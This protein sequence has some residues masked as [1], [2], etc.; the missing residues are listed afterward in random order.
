M[1]LNRANHVLRQR[2]TS[3][4]TLIEMI[5]SLT[6]ISVISGLAIASSREL[7]PRYRTREAAREFANAVQNARIQAIQNNREARIRIT[8]YDP[9]AT[10]VSA[11]NAGAWVVELGN[12]RLGSSSWST[13]DFSK[14]DISEDG[15]EYRKQVS[16][17]YD[18]GDLTGPTNCSCT[19][20][21][22][23][24]PIGHVLNPVDDF[25]AEGDIRVTFVNKSHNHLAVKDTYDIR[26]YRAGMTRVDPSLANEFAAEEGGTA[27]KSS[28]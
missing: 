24:S 23:F 26:I 20:S 21:V 15:E 9:N 3:G 25:E 22:V 17:K 19:D 16:L 8:D 13:V 18:S 27:T 6:I 12:K 7:L 14:H 11:G 4:F 10:S 1:S 28:Y 5:I 2:R